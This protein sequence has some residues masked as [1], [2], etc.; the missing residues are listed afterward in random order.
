MSRESQESMFF[1]CGF[2]QDATG[3][4]FEQRAM[5]ISPS[6]LLRYTPAS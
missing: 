5:T 6:L 4:S 1:V 3:H 2:G